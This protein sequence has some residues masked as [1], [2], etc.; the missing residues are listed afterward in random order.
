MLLSISWSS[1]MVLTPYLIHSILT[2]IGGGL[3]YPHFSDEQTA[4]TAK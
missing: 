4:Y 1:H 2:T 3:Y